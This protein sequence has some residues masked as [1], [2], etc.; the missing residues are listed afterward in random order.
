MCSPP[1]S[2]TQV[3]TWSDQRRPPRWGRAPTRLRRA[4]GGGADASTTAAQRRRHRQLCS[5]VSLR[6]ARVHCL[7]VPAR[8]SS[9]PGLPRTCTG[10]SPPSP[11]IG[12]VGRWWG[13]AISD[14]GETVAEITL[15]LFV[16][17][18]PEPGR[19]VSVGEPSSADWHRSCRRRRR[20]EGDTRT[21]RAETLQ[22]ASGR[23]WEGA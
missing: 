17:A 12:M 7:P 21:L 23:E 22:C 5:A 3:A 1:P 16:S 19:P 14:S 18:G 6:V 9:V 4:A 8:L 20:H 2:V 10:E 11:L 13:V 15:V